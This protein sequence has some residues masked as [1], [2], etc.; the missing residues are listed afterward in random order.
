[1]ERVVSAGVGRGGLIA[2][3]AEGGSSD[4]SLLVLASPGKDG[5]VITSNTL[6][7]ME[8]VVSIR[9]KRGGLV[10]GFA[11]GGSSNSFD[12]SDLFESSNSSSE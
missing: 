1:M 9:V 3:V 12:S 2:E 8:N 4:S 11:K 6:E 5:P 7:P 10:A